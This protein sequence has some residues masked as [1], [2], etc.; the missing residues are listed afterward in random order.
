MRSPGS[1]NTWHQEEE[2]MDRNK[3]MK[4]KQTNAPKTHEPALSSVPKQGDQNTLKISV[5]LK[6]KMHKWLKKHFPL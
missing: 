6:D 3:H 2:K 4:N 1:A 5:A